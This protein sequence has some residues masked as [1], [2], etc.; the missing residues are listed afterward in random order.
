[1]EDQKTDDMEVRKSQI[2]HRLRSFI[3]AMAWVLTLALAAAVFVGLI[4]GVGLA[5]AAVWWA[6]LQGWNVIS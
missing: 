1:M 5:A 3:S 6:F 4:I 2:G